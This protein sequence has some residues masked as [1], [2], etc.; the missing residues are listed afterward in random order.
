MKHF[1]IRLILLLIPFLQEAQNTK[2]Y[3]NNHTQLV[4]WRFPVTTAV[5]RED[6]DGDGDPDLIRSFINDSI[7][8]IWIDDD[9]DMKSTDFEGDTD[10]DCLLVD[11]N[12]DGIFAGPFDFNCHH[13]LQ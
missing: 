4:P 13:E 7:P 6:L 9:D 3:W 11:R 1:E 5:K 10:N 8:V 12:R 2:P